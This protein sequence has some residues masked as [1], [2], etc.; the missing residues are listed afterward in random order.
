MLDMLDMFAGVRSTQDMLLSESE[1]MMGIDAEL[2]PALAAA[3]ERVLNDDQLRARLSVAGSVR[4]R[5]FNW[6]ASANALTG[7][8]AQAIERRR[9]TASAHRH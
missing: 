1:R 3:L 9:E 5:R 4:A 8:Y 2:H 7:A 6:R